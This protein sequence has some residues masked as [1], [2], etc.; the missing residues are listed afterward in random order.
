MPVPP[1]ASAKLHLWRRLTLMLL[2]W[3]ADRCREQ[4]RFLQGM[5]T[6]DVLALS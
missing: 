3:P 2:D 5:S 6:P 4:A 1:D